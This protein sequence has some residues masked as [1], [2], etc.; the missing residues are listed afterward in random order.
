MLSLGLGLTV[1]VATALI[2]GNLQ[3]QIG[4]R[5]PKDAP[6]FFV[7]DLQPDQVE[8]FR[9]R[10][11]AQNVQRV[12]QVP[13]LRGRIA[14]IAGTPVRELAIPQNARWAVESD[15]GLTYAAT[16]PEGSQVVAGKW[17]PA[18][19]KGPPLISFDAGLAQAFGIGVGDTITV[20]ILGRDVEARIANLRRI[21][22]GTL[23][24][25]FTFIFAP[26]TLEKAPQ[27]WLATVYAAGNVEETA[28]RTITDAFAN[29]TVV[30]VK[31][32]LE[33]A[34]Q[35]LGNIGL[36]ARVV[37]V[38]GIVAGLL[39]LAGAMLATQRRRVHDTVVMKVL[40]AT[41][42]RVLGVFSYEF[43]ALGLVTA[44][45]ATGVGT[46]AA[47]L[48]VQFVMALDWT[49]LPEVALVTAFG[50]MILTLAFG[51]AGAL[52]ALR[53]RPLGLLRNE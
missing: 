8:P 32:A 13:M 22:W 24:I 6:A 36:A 26:G 39:V 30:R 23:A 49:F 33:T 51:L 37:G 29:V 5:I 20:N 16:L 43:A 31:D 28:Y 1:L 15:R 17:W 40:G 25:N 46:L 45:A 10:L 44:L 47:W 42:G 7:V 21:D 41:S 9:A 11:Q 48:V 4:Q 19:Y 14:K 50:A 38:V 53:Q 35:I 18:D 52:S 34:S 3:N 12:E 2:E 27:T